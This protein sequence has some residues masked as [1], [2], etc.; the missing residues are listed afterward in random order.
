MISVHGL[1]LLVALI[2]NAAANLLM[3][4]GMTKVAAGG[5]LLQDGVSAAAM[6][7]LTS[8]ILIMGLTCF[9]LN[10]CFYMF[11]L[12]SKVL[13]ISLA[14]PLMVGG[15]YAIIAVVGY[16]VLDD[17]LSLAQKVGVALILGGVILIASRARAGIAA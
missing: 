2:L 14:Y 6:K 9:A 13:K 12:Q 17:R 8:P 15:G 5:G 1:A 11:A 7:V 4:I 3:K 10:A 16:Y